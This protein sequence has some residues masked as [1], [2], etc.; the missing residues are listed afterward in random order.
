[1]VG[2]LNVSMIGGSLGLLAV[3]CVLVLL[4]RLVRQVASASV[5][6]GMLR[7]VAQLASLAVMPGKDNFS[8]PLLGENKKRLI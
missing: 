5:D 1:M 2:W 4:L 8:W 3:A 7:Q 6:C